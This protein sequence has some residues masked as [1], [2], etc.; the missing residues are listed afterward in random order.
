MNTLKDSLVNEAINFELNL[1]K[2]YTLF[3]DLFEEDASFWLELSEEEMNHAAAIRKIKPF[4]DL[5][6]KVAAELFQSSLDGFKKENEVLQEIIYSFKSNPDRKRALEIAVD[7]EERGVEVHYQ[8][9]VS[10]E[11]ESEIAKLFIALNGNDKD[12]AQHISTYIKKAN[13]GL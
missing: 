6:E 3:K 5:D 1:A 13:I 2:I 9:F 10:S 7:I 11:K 4:F 8:A 12:H